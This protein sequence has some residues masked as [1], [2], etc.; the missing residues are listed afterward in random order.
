[1]ARSMSTDL[2]CAP[3]VMPSSML[4]ARLNG[5][6]SSNSMCESSSRAFACSSSEGAS[7]SVTPASGGDTETARDGGEMSSFVASAHPLCAGQHVSGTRSGLD[8]R[9]ECLGHLPCRYRSC[10]RHDALIRRSEE[11]VDQGKVVLGRE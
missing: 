3:G 6:M 2:T 4:A 7:G 5:R 1:M 9:L 11:S 10:G 8:W